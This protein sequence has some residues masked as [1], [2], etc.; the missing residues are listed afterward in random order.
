MAN[1]NETSPASAQ[2]SEVCQ[3][4]GIE[5]TSD[6]QSQHIHGLC[7]GCERFRVD[8]QPELVAAL[9]D[10]YGFLWTPPWEREPAKTNEL[11]KRVVALLEKTTGEEQ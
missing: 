2:E 7:N 10:L 3:D 8:T 1:A 9:R 4:C 5:V 6:L 11:G